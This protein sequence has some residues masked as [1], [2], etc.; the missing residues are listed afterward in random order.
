MPKHVKKI[1]VHFIKKNYACDDCIKNFNTECNLHLKGRYMALTFPPKY[2]H[3]CPTCN[4][5]Y[6]LE[7]E[8][9]YIEMVESHSQ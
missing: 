8:Y 3:V 9:P 5:E 2:L 6:W 7:R 4:S 1:E